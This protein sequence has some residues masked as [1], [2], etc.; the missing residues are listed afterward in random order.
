MPG[1]FTGKKSSEEFLDAVGRLQDGG[2]TSLEA[3]QSIIV[4]RSK[5]LT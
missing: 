1:K 3:Q 2:I 5:A 4:L